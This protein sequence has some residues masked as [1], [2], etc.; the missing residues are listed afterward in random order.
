MSTLF[1]KWN[2]LLSLI[3][4][5][6]VEM[7]NKYFNAFPLE[8]IQKSFDLEKL[9]KIKHT[10]SFSIV[11]NDVQHYYFLEHLVKIKSPL[12]NSYEKYILERHEKTYRHS[13]ENI[14]IKHLLNHN[15]GEAKNNLIRLSDDYVSDAPLT[16]TSLYLL[17]QQ[18]YFDQEL[19][20][21]FLNHTQFK[22]YPKAFYD[23]VTKCGLEN[24]N[25]EWLQKFNPAFFNLDGSW[26]K[27][28]FNGLPDLYSDAFRRTNIFENQEKLDELFKK[29]VFDSFEINEHT[30]FYK[31]YYTA[32]ILQNIDPFLNHIGKKYEQYPAAVF[33]QIP[34]MMELVRKHNKV[35]N[36]EKVAEIYQTMKMEVI[37]INAEFKHIRP[38]N[39]SYST[40]NALFLPENEA[41]KQVLFEKIKEMRMEDGL[42]L[43]K[44][45]INPCQLTIEQ[46]LFA[47]QAMIIFNKK[48]NSNF[49][50]ADFNS[51][52]KIEAFQ[53]YPIEKANF[54]RKVKVL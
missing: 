41:L 9:E 12:A 52:E 54:P 7:Q 13:T 18:T 25:Q 29:Y 2:A 44:D 48:Y 22:K 39:N 16:E 31:H 26:Q 5:Q 21:R 10:Q 4:S 20:T 36:I 32:P 15:F 50:F 42:R 3:E 27:M 28:K 49:D 33:K 19:I 8:P 23:V 43:F 34:F 53:I 1:D 11:K 6:P 35:L 30:H 40:D 47:K 24:R 14:W 46:T 45:Y 37:N 38:I 17:S 51:L